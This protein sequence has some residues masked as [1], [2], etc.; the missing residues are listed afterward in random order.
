MAGV[1]LKFSTGAQEVGT[2]WTTIALV[3][4]AAHHRARLFETLVSFTG[5]DP[6]QP[7]VHV[8]FIRASGVGDIADAV[9]PAKMNPADP[10]TP[11]TVVRTGVVTE[12]PTPSGAAFDEQTLH[13][14][15]GAMWQRPFGY[16]THIPG[17]GYLLLQAKSEDP[18][19]I[20]VTLGIEE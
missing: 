7:P 9:T 5:V 19:D 6:V 3:S 20:L 4:A 13:P 17:G 18:I 2:G 15:G 11:Q 16:E 8:R 14:Q 1:L 10:E 12:E